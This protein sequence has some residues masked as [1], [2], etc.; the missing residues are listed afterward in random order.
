MGM[1][2]VQPATHLIADRSDPMTS[3][4]LFYREVILTQSKVAL[5]DIE[6]YDRISQHRWCARKSR[7]SH[8]WY[9]VRSIGDGPDQK[10]LHMHREILNMTPGNGLFADH[11]NG[12]GLDNRKLNLRIATHSQNHMNERRR[13]DNKTGYKGVSL[14]TSYSRPMWQANICIN[15]KQI[16]LG[17]FST[18]EL[19]YEAYCAAAKH[20]FG[21]FARL[22]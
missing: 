2:T 4:C 12:D 13:K 9:A 10:L 20:Y 11:I 21:E 15:Q 18:P 3:P 6:D 7:H 22:K 14:L 5:V 17:S 16:Y 8:V 19:A 1:W